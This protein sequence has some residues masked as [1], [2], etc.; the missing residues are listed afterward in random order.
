[1]ELTDLRNVLFQLAGRQ[2]YIKPSGLKDS[3][4]M[5]RSGVR[6]GVIGTPLETREEADPLKEVQP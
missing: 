2:P 1:M 3:S 5:G 6:A 4:E